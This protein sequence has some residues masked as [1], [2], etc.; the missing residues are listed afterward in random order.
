M[1]C[2]TIVWRH[3]R[4]A[5][6]EKA[7]A[8]A[9]PVTDVRTASS[10]IWPPRKRQLPNSNGET[11]GAI[12][13]CRSHPPLLPQAIVLQLLIIG[14]RLPIIDLADPIH[15][16]H[17]SKMDNAWRCS[18]SRLRL[19]RRTSPHNPNFP[20]NYVIGSTHRTLNGAQSRRPW[21]PTPMTSPHSSLNW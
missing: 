12:D 13:C 17:K 14:N 2:L 4:D 1:A 10:Y 11:R 8:L 16:T 7:K 5:I 6:L 9:A 19:N 21:P 15:L 3:P 18:P 20:N